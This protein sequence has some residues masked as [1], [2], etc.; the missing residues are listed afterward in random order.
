MHRPF[1]FWMTGCFAVV[2]AA[3]GGGRVAAAAER[4]VE[5]RE[6]RAS[7]YGVA[8]TMQRLESCAARHGFAVF[9]RVEAA[10]ARHGSAAG[11]A[12]IVFESSRGDGTPVLMDG[13]DARPD[14]PLAVR[15]RETSP[16][17][18]EVWIG[19]TQWD[20]L[21]DDVARDVTELP[22]LVADALS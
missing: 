1:R 11:E 17:R 20:D 22:A 15:V 7:R 3:L 12:V 8:E 19:S 21:P 9:A 5:A 10:E 14:L 4:T 2:M 16:G 18:S 13:P 6:L